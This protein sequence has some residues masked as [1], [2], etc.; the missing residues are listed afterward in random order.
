MG[1]KYAKAVAEGIQFHHAQSVNLSQNRLSAKGSAFLL[2]KISQS[3]NKLDF[4]QNCIGG[5]GVQL[6]SSSMA[7]NYSKYPFL[8]LTLIFYGSLKVLKLSNC[9]FTKNA[10]GCICKGLECNTC[11]EV[12]DLSKNKIS[13]YS[14]MDLGN[15]LSIN[16]NLKSL[17]LHWNK[18][19]YFLIVF[20]FLEELEEFIS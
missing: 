16:Q 8:V 4:S 7:N 1:D 19:K 6:L 10:I 14:C 18:I 3:V 17:S 20:H 11:V 5:K 13:D 12:L 2:S 15:L 9:H